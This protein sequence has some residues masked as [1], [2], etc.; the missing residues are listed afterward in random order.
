LA[1]VD[2]GQGED[3]VRYV[4]TFDP[5]LLPIPL[6][7]GKTWRTMCDR[8]RRV[9]TVFPKPP[10]A[11][12][13]KDQNIADHLL[14]ARLPQEPSVQTRAATGARQVGVRCCG[15]GGRRQLCPLYPMCPFLGAASDPRVVVK[16]DTSNHTVE[17]ITITQ[18]IPC[19]DKGCLHLISCTKNTCRKQYVGETGRPLYVRFEEQKDIVETAD[20]P[21]PVVQH[22][23]LPGHSTRDMVMVPLVLVRGDMKH[24]IWDRS[25][26]VYMNINHVS[27]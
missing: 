1:N 10:Q 17:V 24:I 21:C 3:R 9:K 22:F 23:Q 7:L 19:S 15:R 18:N 5:R 12:M 2:R 8:D 20:T 26:G 27:H 25:H 13:K 6:V 11:S 16:E 14:R 4:V